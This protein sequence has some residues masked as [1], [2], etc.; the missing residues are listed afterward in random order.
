MNTVQTPPSENLS[1]TGDGSDYAQ[2]GK[3]RQNT[4]DIIAKI[5]LN[6]VAVILIGR[7]NQIYFKSL[8]MIINN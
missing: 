4:T 2:L 6:G 8:V 3:R 5:F 7:L 1:C